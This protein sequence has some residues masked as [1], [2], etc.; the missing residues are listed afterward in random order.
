M[1]DESAIVPT[2]IS[3]DSVNI[4]YMGS[5]PNWHYLKCGC[6]GFKYDVAREKDKEPN[7]FSCPSKIHHAHRLTPLSV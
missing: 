6:C 5:N 3:L 7:W 1:S 2:W 4:V